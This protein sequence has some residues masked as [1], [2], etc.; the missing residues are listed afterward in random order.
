MC[1]P[2]RGYYHGRVVVHTGMVY[3]LGESYV[4][5]LVKVI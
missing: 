3:P 5:K 2:D 4:L 1:N